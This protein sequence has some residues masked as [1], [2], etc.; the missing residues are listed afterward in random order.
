MDTNR[1]SATLSA[2]PRAENTPALAQP[3]TALTAPMPP[4]GGAAVLVSALPRAFGRYLLLREVAAGG[5]GVVYEAHDPTLDRVVA[6]KM[7]RGGVFAARDTVARFE[8]EARAAAQLMHTHIIQVHDVGEVDGQHFFT[9]AFAPGGS[10]AQHM[11]EYTGDVKRTVDLVEKVARAVGHAHAKGILHRD[12]KPGN[13]LLDEQR[14]PLVSD[15]GLAKFVDDSV[16]LT[17][18]G[19]RIGTPAYMA[20]EQAAGHSDRFGPPTDVWALG[21]VLYQLLT[22]VRPFAGDSADQLNRQILSSEPQ[23]PRSRRAGIDRALDLVVLK[24]LEKEPSQRY[25][26]ASDLADDLARWQRGEPPLVK[27]PRW[28]RRLMRAARRQPLLVAAMLGVVVTMLVLALVWWHDPERRR[29]AAADVLGQQGRL[30]LIGQTG[31]PEHAEWRLRGPNDAASTDAEVPYEVRSWSRSLVELWRTPPAQGYCLRGEVWHSDGGSPYGLVGFYVGYSKRVNQRGEPV[32]CF[33]ALTFNDTF[34]LSL[35]DKPQRNSARLAAMHWSVNP[36][37]KLWPKEFPL[38]PGL[39]FWPAGPEA[40]GKPPNYRKVE[41]EVRPAGIKAT[42]DG[43][44]VEIAR[45]DLLKRV[46]DPKDRDNAKGGAV[47][48]DYASGEA[49]G[50]FVQE[51]RV[52][53]RNVV[54]EALP[55]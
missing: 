6:L 4:V 1:E 38:G 3:A 46:R 29:A 42:F 21:V 16:E 45:A 47:E 36:A 30:I 48:A 55:Q 50:L 11:K 14:E 33:V 41:L 2:T 31:P 28:P 37:G 13:I 25:S 20:P 35:K 23:S 34:S 44:V 26:S 52:R 7:I 10:L 19:Q 51:A 17:H 43:K 54:I 9:M 49:L 15:F 27:P 40:E 32:H 39:P 24:C 5:M 22:G 8:T 18:T 53:F 12:L